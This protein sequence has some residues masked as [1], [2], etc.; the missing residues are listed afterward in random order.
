M[1]LI[2]GLTFVGIAMAAS[3]IFKDAGIDPES[4]YILPS[5]D[6]GDVV[7]G[8]TQLAKEIFDR[9]G[10]EAY[11]KELRER[12]ILMAEQDRYD[13]IVREGG[14][15]SQASRPTAMETATPQQAS[16]MEQREPE[17]QPEPVATRT[18]ESFRQVAQQ[19]N[20]QSTISGAHMKEEIFAD[21][22]SALRAMG[23][24]PSADAV[25]EVVK[26]T[27]NSAVIQVFQPTNDGVEWAEAAAVYLPDATIVSETT[28]FIK[29]AEDS[30]SPGISTMSEKFGTLSGGAKLAVLGLGYFAV[31]SLPSKYLWVA[32]GLLAYN[33]V[34]GRSNAV[35]A[36]EEVST[37][38]PVAGMC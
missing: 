13:Q 8:T 37:N 27:A 25:A 5:T 12:R 14:Y 4:K 22:G 10:E 24:V 34:K 16:S 20:R 15:P 7:K 23:D 1:D 6:S 11:T 31:K 28:G 33:Q 26:E 36:A 32:A 30:L 17:R 3:K 9:G 19:Q 35:V 38:T 21:L 2:K 29:N 18:V